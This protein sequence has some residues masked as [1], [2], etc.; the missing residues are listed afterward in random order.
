MDELYEEQEELIDFARKNR[1]KLK[2]V[3]QWL[4]GNDFN[5]GLDDAWEIAINE[6][7]RNWRKIVFFGWIA[8]DKNLYNYQF[9][10]KGFDPNE[11]CGKEHQIM[12]RINVIFGGYYTGKQHPSL[13]II[14]IALKEGK[15]ELKKKLLPPINTADLWSCP[16]LDKLREI[17]SN[18]KSDGIAGD[19]IT[20][21]KLKDY[22]TRRRKRKDIAE[23]LYH[24]DGRVKTK[25][26]HRSMFKQK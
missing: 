8:W 10:I 16:S 17:D 1:E 24:E 6:S 9:N 20:L 25:M 21:K 3:E 19:K 22:L 7:P 18:A 4:N 2:P 12:F 15:N 13:R 26:A 23:T 14:S 5:G 11:W